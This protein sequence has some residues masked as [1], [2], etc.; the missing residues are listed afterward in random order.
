MLDFQIGNK[1]L[2]LNKSPV[3]KP[4]KRVSSTGKP[5]IS[6]YLQQAT[7]EN[8]D[9]GDSSSSSKSGPSVRPN[10]RCNRQR[11]LEGLNRMERRILSLTNSNSSRSVSTTTCES[12]IFRV[13]LTSHVFDLS[14]LLNENKLSWYATTVENGPEDSILY[15][16]IAGRNEIIMFGGVQKDSKSRLSQSDSAAIFNTVHT[17]A[18]NR[19]II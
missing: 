16:L 19:T 18:A 8:P 7:K 6:S 1:V 4:I 3:A 11:L 12:P 17:I 13:T 9:I 10:A 14:T 5:H 2:V 15:T